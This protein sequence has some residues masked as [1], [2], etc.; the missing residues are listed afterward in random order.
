MHGCIFIGRLMGANLRAAVH[1]GPRRRR[2]R[3]HGG[4]VQPTLSPNLEGTPVRVQGWR[5]TRAANALSTSMGH[6]PYGCNAPLVPAVQ[7]RTV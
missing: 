4:R 3:A 5:H 6:A 7:E 1:G 2:R